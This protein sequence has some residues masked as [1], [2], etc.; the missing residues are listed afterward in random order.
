MGYYRDYEYV[1]FSEL[2]GET[3]IS[4]EG[5]KK[6]SEEI[7]FKC[8]SGRQFHLLHEQDCCEAVSVEDIDGDASDI[9]GYEVLVADETSNEGDLG[10]YGESFTWT[11]YKI[12]TNKGGITIRWYG[13]SNGYYSERATFKEY[14]GAKE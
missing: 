10:D 14:I 1:G 4:V 8:L 13:T 5:L 11:Y 12:D 7:I 2:L 9:I 6:D 3:L